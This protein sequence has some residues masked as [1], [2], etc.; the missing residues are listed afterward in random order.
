MKVSA[1]VLAEE[2]GKQ[3]KK[4]SAAFSPKENGLLRAAMLE[5]VLTA[6]KSS[7]IS[8]IVIVGSYSYIPIVATKYGVSFISAR[9]TRS[10]SFVKNIFSRCWDAVLI[11]SNNIPL[12]LNNDIETIV[13]LGLK[14]P[15]IVLSPTLKGRASAIFI[16]P[17]DLVKVWFGPAAF[18][19]IV[20]KAIAEDL[21]LK[22]YSSRRMTIDFDLAGDLWKLLEIENNTVS[23]RVFKKI[24]HQKNKKK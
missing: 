17:A 4:L 18:Y 24:S 16:N 10:N 14:E 22:F 21:A 20:K 1:V 13:E 7:K 6:L 9:P 3:R 5:D 12:V 19:K 23:K 11:L 8:E 15:S 2:S